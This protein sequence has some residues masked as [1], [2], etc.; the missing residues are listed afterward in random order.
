MRIVKSYIVYTDRQRFELELPYDARVLCV[1]NKTELRYDVDQSLQITDID[2]VV[3]EHADRQN[4]TRRQ[5]VWVETGQGTAHPYLKY[6]GSIGDS[7]LFEE[8]S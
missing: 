7:H 8:C 4:L 5:F 6:V 1:Q 3:L 2:L